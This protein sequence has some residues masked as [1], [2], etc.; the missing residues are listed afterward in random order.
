M[1]GALSLS[2]HTSSW[3]LLVC[4][5]STSY[6]NTLTSGV[7]ARMSF[8]LNP[9]LTHNT[10]WIFMPMTE[11]E[12]TSGK[13]L[14]DRTVCSSATQVKVGHALPVCHLDRAFEL[15]I[16]FTCHCCKFGGIISASWLSHWHY[17]AL[18]L[19]Q[20]G[21]PCRFGGVRS[22]PLHHVVR[23]FR[24]PAYSDG[25]IHPSIRM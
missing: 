18:P 17:K 13:A 21:W 11:W 2:C 3:L 22:T 15:L 16:R 4:R 14:V 24:I 25:P 10:W 6:D 7:L 1:P 20:S 23:P 8:I 12:L 19:M 5:L 9:V